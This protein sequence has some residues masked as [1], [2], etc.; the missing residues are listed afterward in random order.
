MNNEIL[1]E[2]YGILKKQGLSFVIMGIA[3]WYFYG[4][5][6]RMQ[7]EIKQ[8]NDSFISYMNENQI[9]LISVIEKNTAALE[10]LKNER[11]N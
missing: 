3:I 5:Q 9:K 8:C 11:K 1:M 4:E 10:N 2:F 6:Q 7:S